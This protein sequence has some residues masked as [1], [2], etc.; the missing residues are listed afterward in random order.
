MTPFPHALALDLLLKD[1]RSPMPA[2]Y[3]AELLALYRLCAQEG[4]QC[5]AYREVVREAQRSN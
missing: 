1:W 3:R 5:R 4:S 2:Q